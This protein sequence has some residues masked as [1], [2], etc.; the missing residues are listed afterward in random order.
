VRAS[1]PEVSVGSY[2]SLTLRQFFSVG[3]DPSRRNIKYT[4]IQPRINFALADQWHLNSAPNIQSIC[5]QENGSCH[6]MLL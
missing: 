2:A 5:I 6:R 1:L 4:G 3:G